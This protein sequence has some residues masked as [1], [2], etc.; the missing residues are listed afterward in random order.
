MHKIGILQEY[1]F[2]RRPIEE[3]PKTVK[4]GCGIWEE[5]TK[6]KQEEE[7]ETARQNVNNIL[8]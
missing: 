4:T 5:E 2:V 1:N 6:K 7:E 8:I 3:K